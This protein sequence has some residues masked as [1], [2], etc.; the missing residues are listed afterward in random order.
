[1]KCRDMLTGRSGILWQLEH[2]VDAEVSP[3]FAWT[4]RT[5]IANWNDP[6]A[7]VV[8]NG[9]FIAGARGTTLLPDQAPLHWTIREVRQPKSFVIEMQLDGAVLTFEWR[10]DGLSEHRTRMTQKISLVGDNA[11]AYVQAVDA[12]FRPGLADGMNRIAAE[13]A[14]AEKHLSDSVN[15]D[16]LAET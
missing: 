11:N 7:K 9:P 6:P 15:R 8:L 12:G 4:Y 16:R 1:M 5:N 10:F 13:A 3:E 14:A 2:S